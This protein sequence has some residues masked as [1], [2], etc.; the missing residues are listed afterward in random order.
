MAEKSLDQDMEISKNNTAVVKK[1][2]SN[3]SMDECK[4]D[5]ER[6]KKPSPKYKIAQILH[7]RNYKK[8]AAVRKKL[9]YKLNCII[10]KSSNLLEGS[11]LRREVKKYIEIEKRSENARTTVTWN[12]RCG[13]IKKIWAGTG[14]P[15]DENILQSTASKDVFDMSCL[16]ESLPSKADASDIRKKAKKLAKEYL[17][18]REEKIRSF[19]KS[20]II[21]ILASKVPKQ[22]NN[23][24]SS[25]KNHRCRSLTHMVKKVYGD[26]KN[27]HIFSFRPMMETGPKS[28]VDSKIASCPELHTNHKDKRKE[29]TLDAAGKSGLRNGPSQSEKV[30]YKWGREIIIILN[31]SCANTSKTG[32]V[33][34]KDDSNTANNLQNPERLL[35]N[36]DQQSSESLRTQQLRD[37]ISLDRQQSRLKIANSRRGD[38][39][40]DVE[41]QKASAD[42]NKDKQGKVA[43]AHRRR[44]VVGKLRE[45]YRRFRQ[46]ETEA[47]KKN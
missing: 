44:E 23:S 15:V 14:M 38:L 11:E 35:F 28:S 31:S 36:R 37:S 39:S 24:S 10:E 19:R 25:A 33:K 46:H 47:F 17:S 43:I 29:K 7:I 5:S 30:S 4:T 45:G 18:F 34:Q 8:D 42:Q 27:V 21:R 12:H 13:R 22:N 2:A 16:F 1:T 32:S 41:I 40:E 20:E 9:K 6:L 3:G 26:V